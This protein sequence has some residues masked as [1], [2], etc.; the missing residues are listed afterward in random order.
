MEESL[1]YSPEEIEQLIALTEELQTENEQ[2]REELRELHRQKQIDL[3]DNHRLSEEL[4]ASLQNITTLRS[5]VE[6]LKTKLQQEE[7]MHRRTQQKSSEQQMLSSQVQK[8][9]QQLSEQQQQ[10][11]T[12]LSENQKLRSQVQQLTDKN[13]RLNGSDEQLK[14]A[15]ELKKQ[16]EQREKQSKEREKQATITADK[17]MQEASAAIARAKQREEEAQRAKNSAEYHRN[18]EKSLIEQEAKKLNQWFKAEWSGMLVIIAA[19]GI[20]VTLL[21]I[22]KS[23]RCLNDLLAAGK[24]MGGFFVGVY[25]VIAFFVGGAESIGERIS[26]PVVATIVGDILS[27]LSVVV[28]VG[29]LLVGFYFGGKKLLECISEHCCDEMTP[30]VMLV[31]LA[32]LVW[33]AEH[34]PWN[35]IAMFIGCM[36]IYI[37]V[38]WYIDGYKK[39]R[40]LY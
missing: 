19:Y 16:S 38:R 8:L 14:R 29:V 30:V 39:A 33:F 36:A 5:S 20:L 31:S 32:I 23:E 11:Q 15:E 22:G 10:T 35:I 9:T 37:T 1:M 27:I 4:Q 2:Q 6:K 25:K 12:L 34:M 17:A 3:S 26:Q 40:G 18:N 24:V 21:T 13:E 28:C 7:M